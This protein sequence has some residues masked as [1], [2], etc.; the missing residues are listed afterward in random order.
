MNSN[1]NYFRQKFKECGKLLNVKPINLVSLKYREIR[2]H[3]YYLELL[4]HLKNIKGLAIKDIGN[5][6]NGRAYFVSYDN[7][8]I[9]LVEHETG[10]EILYIA[11]SIAGLIGLILQISSMISNRR[12]NFDSFPSS[13]EDAE[14]RYFDNTN[15]FIEERKHHYLPY[16]IFLLPRSNNADIEL[17]KNKIVKLE[18]KVDKLTKKE[19]N[20][21]EIKQIFYQE[22]TP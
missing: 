2:D 22:V 19:T 15:K 20:K 5:A 4:G 17:L 8:N 12:H 6:L 7:Q 21:K 9:I 18:K 3:H 10:L 11:G 16:E 1:E 13:F 14:V